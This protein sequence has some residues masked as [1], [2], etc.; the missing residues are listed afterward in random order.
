MIVLATSV[1]RW[2]YYLDKVAVKATFFCDIF[3][4]CDTIVILLCH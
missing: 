3:V 4:I 2:L 1:T